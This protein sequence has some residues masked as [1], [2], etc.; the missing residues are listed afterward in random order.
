MQILFYYSTDPTTHCQL[1][2]QIISHFLVKNL[3]A[4]YLRGLFC[5]SERIRRDN[6]STNTSPECHIIMGSIAEISWKANVD[7]PHNLFN[8]LIPPSF[9]GRSENLAGLY[10]EG[11]L[12]SKALEKKRKKSHS[13]IDMRVHLDPPHAMSTT[14]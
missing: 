1:A 12:S 10:P 4:N 9:I 11:E 3:K 8:W 13:V 2:V 6:D 5:Q 7:L 14:S